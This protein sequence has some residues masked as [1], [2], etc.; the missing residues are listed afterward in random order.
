MT[1]V[2]LVRAR[3]RVCLGRQCKVPGRRRRGYLSG[4]QPISFSQALDF[5]GLA[6][7]AIR[8]SAS[9]LVGKT[10]C[11]VI[12]E[13]SALFSRL[14]T[15]ATEEGSS[16]PHGVQRMCGSRRHLARGI[17]EPILEREVS[18]LPNLPSPLPNCHSGMQNANNPA[19]HPGN[20][21]SEAGGLRGSGS[22]CEGQEEESPWL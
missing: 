15:P 6:A 13:W 12:T 16:Q 14:P 18:M 10:Y 4:R 19:T 22:R 8:A 9:W 3:R 1:V 7:V 20:L 21:A 5:C 11:L 17:S 2:R